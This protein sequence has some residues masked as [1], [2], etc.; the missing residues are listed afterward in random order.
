[1]ILQ[2]LYRLYQRRMNDPDPTRRLPAFGFEEKALPYIVVIDQEGQFVELLCTLSAD[3][4]P[5][6]KTYLVPQAVKRS[7]GIAANLL[8]ENLEYAL[9]V[10]TRGNPQRVAEQH[11][12][13]RARIHALPADVREDAGIIALN[14]FLDQ[15]PLQQLA[16]CAAWPAMLESNPNLSFKLNTEPCLICARPEVMQ[17]C[18]PKTGSAEPEA[19][20]LVTG[21]VQ[22]IQIL[23][24]AIK[25]VWGA[26][27]AGANIVSFNADA[28]CSFGKNGMQG[29]N[30]PVGQAAAFGYT[31]ALNDLL[32]KDSLQR[33][34]VGDASTVFWAEEAA[35]DQAANDFAAIFG[36]APKDDPSRGREAVQRVLNWVHAGGDANLDGAMPCYV[37]GLAPNAA[38]ISIR[39][40]KK[41]PLRQLAERTLSH[42]DDLRI[43]G[44]EW[45]PAYPSLF[46][47]LL[48][49]AALHKAENIPDNLG[50]DVLR[51]ILEDICY[52]ASFYQAAL[53]RCRAEGEVST[54][55]AAI[56]KAC[57]LRQWRSQR[58][59]SLEKDCLI[60]LNH[61]PSPLK[62]AEQNA[63]Q[64]GRLFAALERLQALAINDANATIRD[65]WF[66]T[67]MSAPGM[68]FNSLLRLHHHLAKL[69]KTNRGMEVVM[70][71]LIG[72]VMKQ[73]E[74]FP[75]QLSPDQQG[76]FCLGYYHQR[77]DFYT[78]KTD[79]SIPVAA[80]D[81]A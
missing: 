59:I 71:K 34:Q 68:V 9:G 80:S 21:T 27:T 78:K 67:A 40:W 50:G 42:F 81:A 45:E 39:F 79:D 44:P 5:V 63:Y 23:H 15:I 28:Y 54:M 74:R 6:A 26:Q 13:F 70:D 24:T 69:R 35:G 52:P 72:E 51:A 37:L 11:A 14:R 76:M 3:K 2:S 22:P 53:I 36:E 12:A 19:M 65:R 17:A 62:P 1:M 58:N 61:L 20:C 38:R 60:M 8:W 55:R 18:I 64:M 46:R 56:L 49:C 73:I 66:G 57:L 7:S 75:K 47:L 16:D 77:Q 30:A 4:K 25:G 33:V 48:S 29:E 10:D 43:Q 32:K 31:T 41:L